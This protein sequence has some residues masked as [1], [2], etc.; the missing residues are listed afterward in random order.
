MPEARADYLTRRWTGVHT[1][2]E[3]LNPVDDPL[4]FPSLIP[5]HGTSKAALQ[6]ASELRELAD[7]YDAAQAARKDA[8]RAYRGIRE[9]LKGKS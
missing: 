6:E 4:Y 1:F 9:T 7:L 5:P 8:R 3:L 2:I